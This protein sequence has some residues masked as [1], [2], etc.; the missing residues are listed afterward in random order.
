MA[1]V[2]RQID[3]V[4]KQYR[5]QGYEQDYSSGIADF[6]ALSEQDR[7][8]EYRKGIMNEMKKSYAADIK[9]WTDKKKALEV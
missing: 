6:A 9:Y 1:V 8:S 4:R 3:G 2:D 5:D 7:V